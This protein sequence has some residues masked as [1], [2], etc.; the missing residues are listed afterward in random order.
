MVISVVGTKACNA[1]TTAIPS[2]STSAGARISA[3]ASTTKSTISSSTIPV[4]T[5]S[6]NILVKV[7]DCTFASK[8]RYFDVPIHYAS[9]KSN[10]E[11]YDEHALLNNLKRTCIKQFLT[12]RSFQSFMFLLTDLRD[13]HTSDWIERFL[14]TPSLLDYHGTGAFN[15]TKFENW[16]TYFIEMIQMPMERIIVQARR[17]Q[18]RGRRLFNSGSRNNPYL[19]QDHLVEIPIDIN[20]SSL[21]SRIMAVREQISREFCIDLDL[22]RIANDQILPSYEEN[23]KIGRRSEDERLYERTA[24]IS[25]TNNMAMQDFISSPIRKGSFDLLQLLSLHESIHRVLRW[26]KDAGSGK[27]VSFVWLRDYYFDNVAEYFD[28]CQRYGRADDFIEGLLQAVPTIR[29]TGVN[30]K[31]KLVDP[32]S[33]ASDILDMR[34]QVLME[35]MHIVEH[36]TQDHMGLRKN[37]LTQQAKEWTQETVDSLQVVDAAA[38]KDDSGM[39][40]FE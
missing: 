1:F 24:M 12:Q 40:S 22:I 30:V 26:Y 19:Q 39:G 16:D 21:A 32:L 35:W 13:P 25:L 37:I 2:F 18:T 14:D 28:G 34:S 20:P 7:T 5:T 29:T 6:S 33:I 3:A 36:T 38:A 11:N 10:N 27:E 23:M 17:S 4:T 31:N 8:R 15:M 9:S